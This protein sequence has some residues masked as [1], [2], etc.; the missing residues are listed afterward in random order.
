MLL[1]QTPNIDSA[2]APVF[3]ITAPG[4]VEWA[5]SIRV[6]GE[7][8]VDAVSRIR[9]QVAMS[10]AQR[11][12]LDVQVQRARAGLPPMDIGGYLGTGVRIDSN[13]LLL[14][15]GIV[16]ILVFAKR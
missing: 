8:L 6:A 2:Y 3:D 15:L 10:D 1:G 7:S 13:T 12:L 16:A 9:S 11:A 4:I 5:N 14:I